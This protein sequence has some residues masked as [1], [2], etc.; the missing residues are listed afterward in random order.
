LWRQSGGVIPE[1][2]LAVEDSING[3]ISAK[4]AKMKC[5]AV[6]NVYVAGDARFCLAD[7]RLDSLK[8]FRLDLL[9]KL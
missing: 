6:P 4:A 1:H 8:D 2:C 3:I 9:Q 7:I 5:L